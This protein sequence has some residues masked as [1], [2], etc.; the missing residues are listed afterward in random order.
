MCDPRLLHLVQRAAA[1]QALDRGDL[2]AFGLAHRNAAGAGGDA[3]DM[4]GAGAALRNAAA[5]FGAGQSDVLA[6]RPEQRRI[7][8]DV[9]VKGFSVDRKVCH[10]SPLIGPS[11]DGLKN[12]NLSGRPDLFKS[13]I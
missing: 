7:W 2:F 1:C 10:R 4:N 9:D 6:D 13:T 11:T 12:R 8:L 5:V 3:V